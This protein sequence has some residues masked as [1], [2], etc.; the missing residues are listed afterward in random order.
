MLQ[1]TIDFF[2][3]LIFF[4]VCF[5][6]LLV[7]NIVSSS[8]FLCV[9]ILYIFV[10]VVMFRLYGSGRVHHLLDWWSSSSIHEARGRYALLFIYIYINIKMGLYKK[11]RKKKNDGGL[12]VDANLAAGEESW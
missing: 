7:Y 8:I 10:A 12:R 3:F 1:P 9:P 2:S 11:K 6:F 4:F 5:V